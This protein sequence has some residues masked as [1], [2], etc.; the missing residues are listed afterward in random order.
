M[1]TPKRTLIACSMMEDEINNILKQLNIPIPIVWIDRG[2]HNTPEKLKNELQNQIDQLQDQD[3]ILLAFGLCGN[4]TEGICS[5]NTKLILPRFDDCINLL[6]CTGQRTSRALTRADSLY[7]TRGWT[8]DKESIL[9]QYDIIK[10]QYDEEMCDIIFET[11]YG[12]YHAITVIDTG[13]YDTAPVLDYAQQAANLLDLD[14]EISPGSNRILY[15][16]L[17]GDWNE[18]FIILQ[19]GEKISA[20]Y[21]DI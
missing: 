12:H 17:S 8:L 6:L 11:M 1:N 14:V 3:E 9:Q 16:L 4:G 5:K 18:H 20:N 21:F 19:P 13:C 15:Q 7:L 2:F 10:E